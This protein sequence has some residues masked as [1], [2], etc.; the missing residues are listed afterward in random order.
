MAHIA[1]VGRPDRKGSFTTVGPSD[2]GL[3]RSLRNH[4][5]SKIYY[6]S[7]AFECANAWA[8]RRT[9]I[10]IFEQTLGLSPA[11]PNVTKIDKKLKSFK[12]FFPGR[13]PTSSNYQFKKPT[14][15]KLNDDDFELRESGVLKE[16]SQKKKGLYYED[17]D[18]YSKR[19]NTLKLHPAKVQQKA[20][21]FPKNKKKN[22]RFFDFLAIKWLFL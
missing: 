20:I 8:D 2:S 17:T 1:F 9:K 21:L 14:V 5:R 13:K 7:R 4:Y 3:K 19:Y 10:N 16:S 6:M 12:Q 15:N 11:E 18:A 22:S